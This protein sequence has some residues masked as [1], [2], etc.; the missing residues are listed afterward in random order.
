MPIPPNAIAELIFGT[1]MSKEAKME[2]KNILKN[3]LSHVKCY[4]A[5]LDKNSFKIN[6]VPE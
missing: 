1:K 2:I 6:I 5:I 4:S 3:K